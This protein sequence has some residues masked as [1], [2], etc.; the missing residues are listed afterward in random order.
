MDAEAKRHDEINRL[1]VRI[2]DLEDA[3]GLSN[4]DIATAFHLSPSL[5]RILSLLVSVPSVSRHMIEQ[6]LEIVSDAKVAIYRLKL[7]L[8]R[9][10]D[11]DR[12]PRIIIH[13]KRSHGYWLDRAT[14]ERIKQIVAATGGAVEG[15]PCEVANDSVGEEG[16]AGDDEV[17]GVQVEDAA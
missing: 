15:L 10:T 14:K 4:T 16:P 6:Q 2:R 17:E 7:D 3:L 9:Y 8:N 1:K 13:G 5:G 11:A 12:S